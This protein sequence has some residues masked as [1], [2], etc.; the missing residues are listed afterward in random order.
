[1]TNQNDEILNYEKPKYNPIDDLSA[2]YKANEK[3]KP[4]KSKTQVEQIREMHEK[5]P[6][7]LSPIQR[8]TLGFADLHAAQE[9]N[10][11]KEF[12]RLNGGGDG[13]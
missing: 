4:N 7:E 8:L 5:N 13:E 10:R 9:A 12:Q 1:M 3:V 2:W 6:D 11:Q